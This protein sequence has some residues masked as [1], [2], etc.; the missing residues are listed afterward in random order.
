MGARSIMFATCPSVC[1]CVLVCVWGGY[2]NWCIVCASYLRV[3]MILF[4]WIA[5]SRVTRASSVKSMWV[6]A[7]FVYWMSV[8]FAAGFLMWYGHGWATD[9]E[10]GLL[11]RSCWWTHTVF[12]DVSCPSNGT[13]VRRTTNERMRSTSVDFWRRSW[14]DRLCV[15]CCIGSIW[16][17]ANDCVLEDCCLYFAAVNS[18]LFCSYVLSCWLY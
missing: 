5:R 12:S 3:C 2:K 15:S 9:H 4:I 11:L 6:Y 16:L 14:F 1:L 18:H 17:R 10:V 7:T 8:W 13:S